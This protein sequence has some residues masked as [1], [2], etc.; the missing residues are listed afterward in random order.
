LG[1][2]FP[3]QRLPEWGEFLLQDKYPVAES[4]IL[5]SPSAS[6]LKIQISDFGILPNAIST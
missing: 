1:G 5:R 4:R 6:P 3:K 2:V